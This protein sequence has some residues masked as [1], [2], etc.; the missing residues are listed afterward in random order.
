MRVE[1]HSTV[2]LTS[3]LEDYLE[4]IFELVR[5]HKLARVKDI[6]KAR[7]VRSAS[8]IP[9]L[10]KLAE[11]GLITYVKREYI[12][13]TPEG[14]VAARRIYARHR[15]LVRFF[16]DFLGMPDDLAISD[17]CAMEHTLSDRG[18]DH[19][20]RFFEFIESCPEGREF[21]DR[22]GGCSLVNDGAKEC[23]G[24][25]HRHSDMEA[26]A[27]NLTSLRNLTPGQCGRVVR[28]KGTGAIRQ[29]IL[30]M[31]LLPDVLVQLERVSP[32]GDPLWVKFQGSHLSLRAK[33][34]E[35]VL[36]RLE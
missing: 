34:A 31:G 1:N 10:R 15:L 17:A 3:A 29:R 5:D 28:V 12:D 7:N 36:L 18:M 8:V 24:V 23:S 14:E 6:V 9:A 11:L 26:P 35:T 27:E 4:T 21:I 25:C 13:L 20:V 16:R 32:A 2:G 22:F 19:M 33:E 30:D